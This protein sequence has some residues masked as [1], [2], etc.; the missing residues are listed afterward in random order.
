MASRPLKLSEEETAVLRKVLGGRVFQN[1]IG[2]GRWNLT[3]GE[4][5][6]LWDVIERET[7]S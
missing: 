6:I 3:D 2:A 5:T 1:L 4:E 7:Q